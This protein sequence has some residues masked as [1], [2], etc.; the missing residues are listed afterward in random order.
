MTLTEAMQ[1][2]HTVRRYTDRRLPEDVAHQLTQ[3]IR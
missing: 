2:R 1:T 3:R